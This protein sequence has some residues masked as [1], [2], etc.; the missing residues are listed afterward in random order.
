ML[1]GADT[2]I[3]QTLARAK[4]PLAKRSDLYV[5]ARQKELFAHACR[6]EPASDGKRVDTTERSAECGGTLSVKFRILTNPGEFE[7][8]LLTRDNLVQHKSAAGIGQVVQS[9]L[10]INKEQ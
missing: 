10:E 6:M 5:S 9:L 4:K 3:D 7:F 1:I 2:E 8:P